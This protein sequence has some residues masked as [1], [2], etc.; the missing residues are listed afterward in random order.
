M[1]QRNHD[2]PLVLEGRQ[3]LYDTQAKA[4]ACCSVYAGPSPDGL[5]SGPTYQVP[6]LEGEA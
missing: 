5:T 6:W 2:W 3:T 4:L 1:L